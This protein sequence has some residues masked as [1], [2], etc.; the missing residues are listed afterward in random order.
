VTPPSQTEPQA[1]VSAS[2][3]SRV[4]EPSPSLVFDGICEYTPSKYPEISPVP[5]FLSHSTRDLNKVQCS[6][7]EE[8]INKR[9]IKETTDEG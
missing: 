1:S 3:Q 5:K 7:T 6:K 9:K 8:Q 4:P 2:H